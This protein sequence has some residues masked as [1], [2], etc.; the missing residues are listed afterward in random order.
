MAKRKTE[1]GTSTLGRLLA[2]LLVLTLVAGGAAGAW[3]FAYANKPLDVKTPTDFVLEPGS[4]IKAASQLQ[5]QGVIQ[6]T[7]WFTLLGRLMRADKRIK[8][9]SYEISEPTSPWQLLQKLTAGDTAM[10][11]VKIIEGWNWRQLKT[12]LAATPELKHDATSLSDA[13]LAAA[14]KLPVASVEGQF[15]PDTYYVNKGSS[16]LQLL[17]RA[18]RLLARKLDAA[19]SL[20]SPGLPLNSP[21][22]ALILA[23]IV[24]KET[25]KPSDRPMVAGVFANRLRIG[26]RL[27][28]DPTVIYGMGEKYNG[29]LR[30]VDLETD[31]AY[32]TYTRSGLTPTPIAFVGEAALR[33]ATQP[34]QTKALYF[35]ARG[36][37]SS[38]FSNSL[39]EHNAAV[40]KY[41]LNR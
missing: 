9:G 11:A 13:D 39:E 2:I 1:R 26:M 10:V 32:N 33:A 3:L 28:T 7:R 35:V 38:Q 22:E 18:N 25:G 31:T 6:E 14:L 30:R 8:A 19:W 24:E 41:I 5:A 37:G 27:Q 40:R 12:T 21:Q 4:F 17:A 16:E 36:D 15:F 29:S 20:R 34:A 23:S